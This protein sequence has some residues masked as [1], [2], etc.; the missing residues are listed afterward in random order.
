MGTIF[1]ELVWRAPFLPGTSD[2]DQVKRIFQMMGSPEER[3]WPV[4]IVCPG[5]MELKT[6]VIQ[7][8]LITT[9]CRVIPRLSGGTL[10]R[11]SD[12]KV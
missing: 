2:I 1:V 6:R 9:T 5:V 8:C 7:N 11:P 4:S 3:D 10:S 12:L